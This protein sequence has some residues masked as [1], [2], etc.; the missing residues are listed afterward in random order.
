MNKIL[1]LHLIF[2]WLIF[3]LLSV[4]SQTLPTICPQ[5]A[6]MTKNC[7]DACLICDI[8]GFT[9][10][11]TSNF[12]P[13]QLPTGFCT[14]TNH[15][16]RWIAFMAST[17]QLTLELTVRNCNNN[18]G[19]E[20]GIFESLDCIRFEKVS[21][22]DGDV[23]PN[24][25]TR[26]TFTKTIVEGQYYYLVID[27]NRGD[28]CD[29]SVRVVNGSTKVTPL[30]K[31]GEIKGPLK[32]CQSEKIKYDVS[33]IKGAAWHYW[34][35]NGTPIGVGDSKEVNWTT[36]GK[37]QLC[38]QAVNACDD[39][40]PSCIE[41]VVNPVYTDS[42]QVEICEGE[43][44][45]IGNLNLSSS[46]IYKAQLQSINS[47]DSIVSVYLTSHNISKNSTQLNLCEGDTLRFNNKK[48]FSAGFFIDTLETVYGCDSILELEVIQIRC[49]I[50]SKS[51]I[52]NVK[53]YGDKNGSI[54]F[55]VV[56]G[57]PSFTFQ[58][59]NL[60]DP[61]INGIGQIAQLNLPV[62][63][64]NLPKG[65]YQII[66]TDFFGNKRIL[67]I[68]VTEPEPL[69]VKLTQISNQRFSL[70]CYGDKNGLINSN[71]VG[72]TR[73]YSFL[74]SNG[75]TSSDI[76]N[77]SA[78]KYSLIVIDSNNCPINI[79]TEL[80]EPNSLQFMLLGNDPTCDNDASGAIELRN[81]KG[82]V[83]PYS[84]SLNNMAF[85]DIWQF[86]NLNEGNYLIVM[87]DDNGCLKSGNITITNPEHTNIS[88]YE[89]YSINLG[90]S[91]KIILQYTSIPGK[92]QWIP[93]D[94]LS[95]NDCIDPFASPVNDTYYTLLTTS[96]DGC[97]D[98]I[99]V[100][101]RVIKDKR[102]WAP[103]VF[104][105]NGDGINDIFNITGTRSLSLIKK[106][107]IFD[108]W[109]GMVY[110]GTKL[111]PTDPRTG[112]NGFFN[113][114]ASSSGVYTWSVE[115]EFLDGEI[116]RESGDITLLR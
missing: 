73:P 42:I 53:C 13:G 80:T 109:G 15:N 69:E 58:Y 62:T 36:S 79:E 55:E 24:S 6:Y 99:K 96:K 95:C 45:S 29:Y 67:T 87:K 49:N 16:I 5:P 82:G 97:I 27:G 61:T 2:F 88:K 28:V 113:N 33:A 51:S 35:L 11:N 52:Q 10:R 110:E 7:I 105:P 81:I 20:V 63:I 115:A 114:Q 93:S 9:G 107:Q 85:D 48:Y 40:P 19:L 116:V 86:R 26:L 91:V 34:Y 38:A 71:I 83:G 68:Q 18:D 23:E 92:I 25:T 112:W 54:T 41:V 59:E 37:F 50:Q 98:S 21:N 57:T 31:S 111:L 75:Q 84:F 1:G 47:C 4:H 3:N 76:R 104:S 39:A 8:E 17:P 106:L 64:T 46:G 90:D 74:W 100:L 101:V 56:D 32:V 60:Q 43:I 108:R 66:I 103:N 30:D 77:L 102:I 22:C 94:H 78:G 65:D 72:G 70:K 12:D 89:D 44:Y 14:T